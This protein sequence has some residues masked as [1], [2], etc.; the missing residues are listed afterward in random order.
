MKFFEKTVTISSD[1][2][3]PKSKGC[4]TEKAKLLFLGE[5]MND[6]FDIL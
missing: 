5:S 4:F 1:K 3:L 6:R 2:K